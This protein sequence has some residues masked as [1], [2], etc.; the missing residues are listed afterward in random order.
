MYGK[1]RVVCTDTI[2]LERHDSA[3]HSWKHEAIS[4]TLP[5]LYL[6]IHGYDCEDVERAV[7]NVPTWADCRNTGK[8]LNERIVASSSGEVC[9]RHARG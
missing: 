3:A 6:H 5:L 7:S 4:K 2:I 8:R 9:D 1:S